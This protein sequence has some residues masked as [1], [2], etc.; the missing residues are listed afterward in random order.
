MATVSTG[1]VGDANLIN[2]KEFL[3]FPTR[4]R[5]FSISAWKQPEFWISA[6]NLFLNSA[7]EQ[8]FNLTLSL[9]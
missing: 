4:I 9:K 7:M 8:N 1:I 2:L 5:K 6:A 3:I